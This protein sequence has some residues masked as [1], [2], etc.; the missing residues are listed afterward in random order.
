[1]CNRARNK[2][3]PEPEQL[4]IH[5]GAD[6]LADR[7]M[8]N[9]F[10]PA[11][12]TPLARAWVVRDNDRGRGVDVMAWDVLGGLAKFPMTNVRQLHLPQWRRLAERPENR[13]LVPVTEF[14]EWTPDK[15]DLGDGKP[16]IKGEMWFQV[17][18]QPQFAIAG[19]WQGTPKGNGFTMV[20]CDPNELVAPVHPKAM[21]TIL[22]P[23][24]WDLW[25]RG[26]YDE[27][28]HLQRP[29]PAERMTVCGPVF[30]TRKVP[31][32]AQ[33]QLDL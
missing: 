13:C 9:R 18:D 19:F 21:V 29:Y 15:H 3:A 1:M 22:D 10:N 25:L 32:P 7:P 12:L 17:Q 2:D 8:D 20:T 23:A 26:S 16:P 27:I 31:P 24:D 33:P 5:Y 30:P 11:E 14:A 4:R 6:W 28:V